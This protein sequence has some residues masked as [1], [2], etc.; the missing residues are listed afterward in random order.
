MR[1][2]LRLSRA[3][4]LVPFDHLPVLAGALHK[5]LGP[6][7]E[8]GGISLYS[9]SW[10]MGGRKIRNGL[11][12]PEGAEWHISALDGEF[13]H[14]SIQ[15]IMSDTD[16]RWGMQVREVVLEPTPQYEQGETYFLLSSPVLIKRQREDGSIAHLLYDDPAS[17]E[18]MTAT[19]RHK[20]QVA[21]VIGEGLNLRFDRD[22]PKAKT[23]KVNY[24]GIEN[25]CS[26]CP[27]IATGTP[28]QLA[29]AWTVGL[30]N[31]TGVGFGSVY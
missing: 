18:L 24:K 3:E 28:D 9:F 30:G 10:L 20:M 14:R 4:E 8:H 19:M 1:L 12:F 16:V 22:Y 7:T 11:M 5:W 17:D 21:G 25:R 2:K 29:F 26:Y 6:N 27:V 31:S 23:Q 13:L 15:G